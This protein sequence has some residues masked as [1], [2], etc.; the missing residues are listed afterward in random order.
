MDIKESSEKLI[1]RTQRLYRRLNKLSGGILGVVRR[2]VERFTQ[3]RGSE[4]AA[5]LAYY[6]FF[7]IFPMLLVFIVIGSFFVDRL[8]VQARL[9]E[10]LQGVIPGAKEVIIENINQVL[11]LRGAVTLVALISLVWSATSVFN[12]LAKNINRAF[13]KADS[14]NFLKGRLLGFLMFLGLG[15]LML[16]SFALS[17]V[18]GL[19]PSINIPLNGKALQE[20]FLW[21]IISLSL[22][23][24]LNMLL[25][26]ATYYWVPIVNVSR[27]ASLI[28]GLVAGIVWQL[29]NRGFT[30]YLS[31]GLSKYRLI[32]GSLGTVVALLF[33]IYLTALIL[34]FGAHLTASIQQFIDEKN[35][36]Q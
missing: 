30:W 16:L 9:L 7:S 8:F 10:I 4:T 34:L 14:L 21:R 33:W 35:A 1:N 24:L 2:A 28:G 23:V 27:K 13:P 6:A 36:D 11:E 5:S 22:P 32:Y 19:I 15:L 18:I 17:T 26:W 3:E 31:S 12:I 29:L 20:T 25:F